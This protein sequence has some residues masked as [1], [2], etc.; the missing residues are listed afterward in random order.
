[1]NR[2]VLLAIALG[3]ATA[4]VSGQ[5]PPPAPAPAPAP[6]QQP[7]QKPAPQATQ[8][9]EKEFPP[10]SESVDVTI[11][12]VEVVVTDSKNNRVPGLTAADFVV[13]QDGIVQTVTNFYAVT[14]G[15]ILLEDGKEL[16]LDKAESAPAVPPDLK[17][18]YVFYIDNLNIQPQNR[19]RMFRRLK[20]FIPQAIGP[21]AEGMV[22]MPDIN[23]HEEMVD[24]I[25]ASRA[26]EANL[27]VVKNARVLAL[28]TLS[29]GKR[30]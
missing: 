10:V 28:Q 29:I 8:P 18:H 3:I 27:A 1:M 2:S 20:E 26:Y 22:A 21:N 6:A 23:L 7:P 12:N 4:G 24:L 15:K 13:R 5:Q 9:Q 16:A 30:S 17:A 19:N 25:A 11:T 14:G